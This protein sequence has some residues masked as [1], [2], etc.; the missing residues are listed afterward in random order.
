MPW[1]SARRV[2]APSPDRA[3][4]PADDLAALTPW[5]APALAAALG[6]LV[7]AVAG[8]VEEVR[9][10]AGRPVEL[11]TPSGGDFLTPD[12]RLT[13]R[14]DEALIVTPEL[15]EQTWQIACEASVYSRIDETRHGYLTLP[16]GHR[17]GVA[18]RVLVEDGRVLRLRDVGGLSFRL[19]RERPGTADPVLPRIWDPAAALP[20][21]TLILSPPGAGKTTLL[22]DLVRQ[23]SRGSAGRGRPGL[24]VALIDERGELAACRSG[25]PCRDVG[26]RTDVLDGCPKAAGIEMA[27]RA[28]NPQVVAFDELGGAADAAAVVEAAHAGV[29]VLA[30]AHAPDEGALARRPSLGGL[31]R[32]GLFGRVVVLDRCP[33][34]G[35]VRYAGPPRPVQ[36]VR[37]AQ[38]AQ[39]VR[40]V[41]PAQ[42]AQPAGGRGGR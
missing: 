30:T 8:Q 28:L 34:P 6:R 38:P 31:V 29:R 3:G 23:L 14:E 35:T 40:P 41:Q 27:V 24:R 19:A 11:V 13:P 9:L 33:R 4:G 32:R 20:H 12:G 2:E 36:P 21:H 5:L 25:R 10:R 37:P 26:P 17:V 15:L 1:R 16:G 42:P 39:P 7:P 18:G 22:R